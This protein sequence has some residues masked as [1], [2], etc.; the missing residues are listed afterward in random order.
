MAS[1]SSAS[2]SV[3]GVGSGSGRGGRAGGGG[4]SATRTKSVIQLTADLDI[5]GVEEAARKVR[6]AAKE[7]SAALTFDEKAFLKSWGKLRKEAAK[8]WGSALAAG[9]K[10]SFSATSLKRISDA[11]ASAARQINESRMRAEMLASKLRQKG[12]KQEEASEIRN[13]LLI[14]RKKL[15]GLKQRFSQEVKQV[16]YLAERREDAVREADE[17][18]KKSW[19]ES[20]ESAAGTFESHMD[21][22]KRGEGLSDLFKTLGK[23]AETGSVQ[24][25]RAAKEGGGKGMEGL[26][27]MLGKVGPALASLGA[28]TA[29]VGV[30]VKMV[31]DADSAMKDLNRTLLDSGATIGDMAKSYDNAGDVID[32]VRKTFT[33][34]DGAF[35]FNRLWGTDAKD[36]LQI[37]GA[38]AE[39]GAT[40]RELGRGAK[41]AAEETD[42]L[43]Q[44]TATALTW[45]RLL[46]KST[47]ETTGEVAGYMEDLGLTLKGVSERF[48]AIH[49]AAQASG[50]GVKR[51]FGQVL[52]ATSGMS[53]YNVRLEEAASLLKSLGKVLGPKAGGEFLQHLTKGFADEGIQERYK[54][55]LL[56]GT[57]NVTKIMSQEAQTTAQE[58]AR[59]LKD[60]SPEQA[61]AVT[62]ALSGAGININEQDPRKL[63]EQMRKLS[64]DKQAGVVSKARIGGAPDEIV[65]QLTSLL[66]LGGARG[67]SGQAGAL[68]QVGMGA[69]LAMLLK[70]ASALNLGPVHKQNFEQRAAFESVTGISGTMY[71]ELRRL[72]A[73]FEKTSEKLGLI[74][75]SQKSGKPYDAAEAER[76]ARTVGV[77]VDREGK[78]RRISLGEGDKFEPGQGVIIGNEMVDLLQTAGKELADVAKEQLPRNEQ[79]ALEVVKNT[80]DITKVLEQGVTYWLEQIYSV[81]Q[82]IYNALGS[83]DERKNREQALGTLSEEV[84]NTH[85]LVAAGERKIAGL[86]AE[87][88]T[89]SPEDRGRLLDQAA[90][91]RK[92]LAPTKGREAALRAI[93][94]NVYEHPADWKFFWES[95]TE[96]DDFIN[97]AIERAGPAAA[98]AAKN[99]AGLTG[100]VEDVLGQVGIR[101]GVPIESQ[102]YRVRRGKKKVAEAAKAVQDAKNVPGGEDL[103]NWI[104]TGQL[105]S[106]SGGLF[107]TGQR[108][109]AGK[110]ALTHAPG[111]G[112]GTT[113][114]ITNN[115]NVDPQG[116][117]RSMERQK[118]VVGDD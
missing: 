33:A 64:A 7:S 112:K 25:A 21:R 58:F 55:I 93:Q 114:N 103:L 67:I 108:V 115:F 40:M 90:E 57:S 100:G 13:A 29:A 66:Q 18:A 11:Q 42:K 44:A 97:R 89:A 117:W 79:L 118:Q 101:K 109:P 111:S 75:K 80:T 84:K 16:K 104:N 98:E 72:S 86:E 45:S 62:D 102:D 32:R 47:Q 71:E 26:A 77:Y 20:A 3:G 6:R 85:E 34:S 43:R 61:K 48:S 106:P 52:Q 91:E 4:S 30:L 110:A 107:D 88:R 10:A 38:Y 74:Q 53:M 14:E 113:K 99:A 49:V 87:A 5:T 116:V 9:A 2:F 69:K 92:N 63:V 23:R 36:H 105:P 54:R 19:A 39:A 1:K 95:K 41:D 35:A 15:D 59:K 94:K 83:N 37:L 78:R 17:R 70:S 8:E 31:I 46:G 60:L 82:G 68:S 28:L 76:M 56:T 50:F 22:L 65:Q 24:A 12:I 73:E 51:F 27:N 96:R 81:T